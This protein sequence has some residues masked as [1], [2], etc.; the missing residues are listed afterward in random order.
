MF[1]QHACVWNFSAPYLNSPSRKVF[2]NVNV[3]FMAK[4]LDF[5]LLANFAYHLKELFR[6]GFLAVQMIDLI[7]A[8][9]TIN[10]ARCNYKDTRNWC[11]C[12]RPGNC[13]C[14]LWWHLSSKLLRSVGNF[15]HP[16]LLPRK[17]LMIVS[18]WPRATKI[19]VSLCSISVIS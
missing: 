9:S 6:E 10:Q 11:H 8:F 16:L 14:S 17:L 19:C 15:I 4:N 2:Y 7:K 12:M 3:H 1:L 5:F 18:A 13:M